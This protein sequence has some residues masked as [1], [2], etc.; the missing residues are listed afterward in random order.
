MLDTLLEMKRVRQEKKKKKK[1][2]GARWGRKRDSQYRGLSVTL[3]MEHY[4]T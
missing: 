1:G 3:S 2:G 4:G